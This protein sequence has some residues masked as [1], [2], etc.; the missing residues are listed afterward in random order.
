MTEIQSYQKKIND[1][2]ISC[3]FLF[4]PAGFSSFIFTE[5]QKD[6]VEVHQ[7]FGR[8]EHNA[9]PLKLFSKKKTHNNFLNLSGK[10][11]V[12]PQSFF[13]NQHIPTQEK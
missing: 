3:L 12:N 7:S 5:G 1:Q 9:T 11:K 2:S 6:P 10:Y 4:W 13:T 8:K